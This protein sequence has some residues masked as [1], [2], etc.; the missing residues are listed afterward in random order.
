MQ[1]I[2][3]QQVSVLSNFRGAEMVGYTP[4]RGFATKNDK[5]SDENSQ[6][7]QE[8]VEAP[9]RKRRSKKEIEAAKESEKAEPEPKRKKRTKLEIKFEQLEKELLNPKIA[10]EPIES[11]KEA[12]SLK[13]SHS[14]L[15]E[16]V[17][18]KMYTLKFNSPILP[19]AKFPLTQNKYIQDFLRSYEQDQK[20]ITRVIGVHFDKNNN[21]N[22][23]GAVGIE[24]EL[25]KKSNITVIE[26]NS[27]KRYQ[28]Q[29]YDSN[30]NFSMAVPFEDQ[31]SIPLMKGGDHND[32]KYKD[33]LQSEVYELKNTWFM[34]NKK[35]NSVL[36][37]LPQE[38]LN[39]YDMMAKS[40]QPPNFDMGRYPTDAKFIEIFDEMT[41]KMA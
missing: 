41:Y 26:S 24:I 5:D 38:I 15:K 29:E 36:V 10:A 30:T 40:L 27:N 14:K 3:Q 25:I 18:E 20:N 8:V 28:V 13:S 32:E 21:S 11:S 39:R 23:K 9:K 16:A 6:S 7:D 1:N 22:A 12:K 2:I 37:I 31:D 33:L 4:T 35:I 17:P 34:Y 19:Y